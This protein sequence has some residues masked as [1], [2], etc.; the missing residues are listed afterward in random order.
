MAVKAHGSAETAEV[1]RRE[2]ARFQ[3][4]LAL[5]RDPSRTL[6]SFVVYPEA[7]PLA[8]AE[9][10]AV[11]LRAIGLQTGLVVAN[12]V[13]PEAVCVH[14]LFRKRFEMQQRYLREIPSRFPDAE[15]RIALL[16]ERE[17]IGLNSVRRFAETV[18]GRQPAA[19]G[20]PV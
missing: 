7:T 2:A 16:R 14:P 18:F 1:D 5:L 4:A 19:A 8:E 3:Q 6:F 12:Q 15:V 10:A 20:A 9:R 17:V 11:D 13:L